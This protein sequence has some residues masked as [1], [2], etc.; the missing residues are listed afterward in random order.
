[1][2][3]NRE[4][5]IKEIEWLRAEINRH[6]HLY[7][8]QAS[9]EISD[10]EYD[11]LMRN[12]QKLETV[13]LDVIPPD[14]PTQRVG[15][16]PIEGFTQI[17]HQVP[18]L[19]LSNTYNTEELNDFDQRVRELYGHEP[20]YVCELK[21]DGVAVSLSYIDRKLAFAV[22]RGD[23]QI[24]DDITN[25]VR[26]IRSIPLSVPEFMLSNFTVRGEIYYPRAEFEKMNRDR[27]RDGLKPFM[28]PRNGAAGTLKMLDPQEVAKRP[29]RFFSYMLLSEIP[30]LTLHSEALDLLKKGNFPVNKEANVCQGLNEVIEYINIWSEKRRSLSYDTDGVVIK[31]ND[32]KAWDRLGATGK[33]P[34][35]AV[36]YKFTTEQVVTKLLDV[37]WQIGRTG[38]VTPVAELEPVLLLGTV[39]K[40][41]TLHNEDEIRRLGIRKDDYVEIEKGGEIIPKVLRFI[42]EKRTDEAE[43]I[44]FL[45]TCPECG[46]E[47]IRDESEVVL[48]CPNYECP[49][50][51][52]G[53]ISH[54]A[55]RG[56]MDID[57]LGA[58]T[59]EMLVDEELVKDIS[60][61]YKL[62]Y[63]R[64][65]QL[66][67]MGEVSAEKLR[68]GIEASKNR[69]FE[70][71]LFGLGIRHVGISV[72]RVLSQNYNDLDSLINTDVQQL[73]MI[74]EVG[75]TIAE[76][77][78]KYF[79]SDTNQRLIERLK[80][81]GLISEVVKRKETPQTLKDKTFVLTGALSGYTRDSATDAIRAKGGSVT[82][83]VSKKTDFVVAGEKPG[84]KYDK[85][86]KLG[87]A[88]LDEEQFI[89]KIKDE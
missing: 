65:A 52:K 38:A 85:A 88:I 44:E 43:E 49:A 81:A 64:I 12:L 9:P 37:T 19:S 58:K 16:K 75:E 26:T 56:A 42:P 87:V 6:D 46:T 45:K 11:A 72:A 80:Q 35:W 62:D 59:V 34:R 7:Y 84:S 14:S 2:S 79:G 8:V 60:D 70:R 50:Q 54:F 76:S 73:Q 41:A 33:S 27:E 68:K 15:G 61:L 31:L 21:I 51:V 20:E 23:G 71:L 78:K 53:R 89:S 29:L 30:N 83:S 1:M 32:L 22:T 77:V 86:I 39:V 47:L 24:G 66:D 55:S 40:R 74:P 10:Q 5:A 48:R 36:A 4:S 25:N 3:Q 67:G 28:N 63:D 82:S 17:Q 18:M 69:S 57:G 13:W